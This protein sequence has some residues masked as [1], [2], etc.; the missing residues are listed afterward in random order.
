[1]T[2]CDLK[3]PVL[4]LRNL[5]CRPET[6]KRQDSLQ[7]RSSCRRGYG[8]CESEAGRFDEESGKGLF[9]GGGGLVGGEAAD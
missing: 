5:S 8:I 2:N 9:G 4:F 3:T 6:P 7:Y 1:M